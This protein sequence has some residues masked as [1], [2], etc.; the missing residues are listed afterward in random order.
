MK[1]KIRQILILFCMTICFFALTGCG[2]TPRVEPVPESIELG[3]RSGARN[4]L[5]QFDSYDD[6]ALEDELQRMK[7]QKNTIMESAILSWQ[8]CRG[9]L[10]RLVTI[11]S[12]SV[13]RVDDSRYRVTVQASYELRELEFIL[14]AEEIADAGYASG[15]ALVPTE[16]TFHPK[17]TTGEKLARAALNTVLGMGTVFA[18]LI[19]I[20]VLIGQL[21]AVNKLEAALKERKE[22]KN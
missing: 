5:T 19:F 14:T 4:Y 7:R 13:E 17:Y 20:S 12:E 15:A 18:V 3:M 22:A 6:A 16:L 10:G 8:S 11:L 9:D 21:K 1:Q 2:S